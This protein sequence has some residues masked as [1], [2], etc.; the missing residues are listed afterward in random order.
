MGSVLIGKFLFFIFAIPSIIRG[1]DGMEVLF[2]RVSLLT[3]QSSDLV[4]LSPPNYHGV[5]PIFKEGHSPIATTLLTSSDVLLP[6]LKL[7]KSPLVVLVGK[8]V[9]D[10]KVNKLLSAQLCPPLLFMLLY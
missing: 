4:V 8:E 5:A 2:E 7:W 1:E 10:S 6:M 9:E 3:E